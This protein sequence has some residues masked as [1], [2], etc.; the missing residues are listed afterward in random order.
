MDSTG[1]VASYVSTNRKLSNTQEKIS[2]KI[3]VVTGASRGIGFA[4]AD[5]LAMA[6][7][8]IVIAARNSSQLMKAADQLRQHG[9]VLAQ[10]CDVSDPKQVDKLFGMVKRRFRRIDVL[11]N[12]AGVAHALANAEALPVADWSKVIATNLTGLFLSTRA[13]LPLMSS[14]STIVNNLSIAAT[15]VF[16]GMAAYNASKHGALGF[17]NTLRE[18]V[19]E[20]GI[21]VVALLPSATDTEIWNQFWPDA[22]RQKMVSPATVAAAVLHAVSLPPEATI[23]ELMIGP[24]VGTL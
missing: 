11:V 2:R 24:T 22:P 15:Q 9:E 13:A 12:N 17:T 8:S 3:A 5:A 4:I 21:R 7:Y 16:K 1:D 19:R 6:G 23:T 10:S 14:G 20:R 18:E